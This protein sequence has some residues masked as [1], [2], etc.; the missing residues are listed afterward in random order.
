MDEIIKKYN[1]QLK[2]DNVYQV[3]IDNNCNI[4]VSLILKNV[5]FTFGPTATSSLIYKKW[6]NFQQLDSLIEAFLT[7]Y[8]VF[9]EEP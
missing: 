5:R 9:K 4:V 8:K 3:W 2:I 6:D 7:F 1:F